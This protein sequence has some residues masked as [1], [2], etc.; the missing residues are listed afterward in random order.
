MLTIAQITDT[1][2]FADPNSKMLEVNTNLTFTQVVSLL[3]TISPKPDMILLTGDLTQDET[4]ASYEFL[5]DLITPVQIPT[6]FIPGNHDIPELMDQVF[7]HFPFSSDKSF[8]RENWHIIL[9]SSYTYRSVHGKLSPE[10]L[11]WLEQQLYNH[12]DRPT[13]IAIHHHPLPINSQWMD[14]IN[15]QNPETLINIIDR[16]PQVKLLLC[17][18]IH[19]EWKY[20]R[21]KVNY[22]GCPSTCVQFQPHSPIMI[23]DQQK[24]GLRL[25]QLYSDGKFTTQIQRVC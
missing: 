2:L 19:Q 17:G 3:K 8:I 25:L 5:S 13:L 4:I 24:P 23:I 22:L 12:S 7:D 1:H 15:L 20:E 16:H 21:E 14:Q 11:T 18:H 10:S 6:Y 9:L